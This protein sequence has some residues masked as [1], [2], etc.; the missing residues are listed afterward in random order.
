[1]IKHFDINE[2]GCSIRCLLYCEELSS[3]RRVVVYGHGFGGHKETRAAARFAERLLKRHRDTAVLCFDWPA[4]GEDGRKNLRLADC[5]TYLRLVT[6]YA[7]THLHAEE[8]YGYATSFGGYLFLKYA[9]ENGSPFRRMVLRCPGIHMYELIWNGIL[10]DND[11][12]QLQKGKPVLAGFDRKVRLDGEFLEDLKRADLS[13]MNCES[14]AENCL[15]VHGMKDEVIPVQDAE[16]F[17]WDQLIE[18]LPV[19]KADHRFSDPKIMDLTIQAILDFLR[20]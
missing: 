15:I 17:A 7:G 4:H 6:A 16:Q 8:L 12:L 18:F 11:R 13:R 10:S 14:F 1:M 2:N 20:L 19:E 9:A 3:I 5:D